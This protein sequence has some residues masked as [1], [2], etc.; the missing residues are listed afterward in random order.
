[1]TDDEAIDLARSYGL[2]RVKIPPL[3]WRSV[4]DEVIEVDLT[5]R[6]PRVTRTKVNPK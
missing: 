6:P 5:C 4:V 1:M 3:A 2:P